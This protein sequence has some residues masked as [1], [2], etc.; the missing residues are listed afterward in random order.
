M[1]FEIEILE[2]VK[3]DIEKKMNNEYQCCE[4]IGKIIKYIDDR[5]HFIKHHDKLI[6]TKHIFEQ[7]KTKDFLNINVVQKY[8]KY[9]EKDYKNVYFR[10]YEFYRK[11]ILCKYDNKTLIDEGILKKEDIDMFDEIVK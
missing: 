2:R 7:M 11:K 8:V 6:E 1:H 4:E 10:F 9:F 3:N 5:K